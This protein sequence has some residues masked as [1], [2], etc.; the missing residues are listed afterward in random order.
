[1][2]HDIWALRLGNTEQIVN[3]DIKNQ[4]QKLAERSDATRLAAWLAQIE[5]MRQNFSVNINRKIAT[6]ALFM[7]MASRF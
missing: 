2:I 4:V 6:D 1:L 7:Q 5:T 3:A